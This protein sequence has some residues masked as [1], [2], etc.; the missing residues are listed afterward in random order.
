MNLLRWPNVWEKIQRVGWWTILEIGCELALARLMT[1][2]PPNCYLSTP[3]PTAELP[4]AQGTPPADATRLGAAVAGVARRM[5]FR[6]LCLQQALAT[7]RMLR[8]RG[9]LATLNLA[10]SKHPVDRAQPTQSREAH[11]WI[12]IGDTVVC[13]GNDFDRYAVVARFD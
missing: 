6:A 4:L 5:P 2:L 8:R 10:I 12:T 1:L 9:H 11:A 7:K 13:G 3:I